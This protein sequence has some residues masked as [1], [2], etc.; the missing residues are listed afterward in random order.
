MDID[1]IVHL[2]SRIHGHCTTESE[3]RRLVQIA[4][5]S[6]YVAEVGCYMGRTTK[7][8]SLAAF[9]GLYAVDTWQGSAEDSEGEKTKQVSPEELY[10]RFIVNLWDEIQLGKILPLRC[11]SVEGAKILGELG[12]TF[13]MIFLDA[14]HDYEWVTRDIIAWLPLLNEGGV[15]VGHDLP[16]PRMEEALNE[17]LPGWK[18]SVGML[19]EYEK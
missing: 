9:G 1:S 3:I 13:D 18:P 17:Y 14:G 5:R 7:A 11:D 6:K 10:R 4:A 15:M 16:H 2:A 19:W 12:Y 8:L